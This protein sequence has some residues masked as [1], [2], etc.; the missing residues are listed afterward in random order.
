MNIEFHLTINCTGF[1]IVKWAFIQKRPFLS[2]ITE[3]CR[4]TCSM[5]FKITRINK[6]RIML[7]K[8]KI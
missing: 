5:D 7:N 6:K 1:L 8:Y 3:T 4:H 2:I